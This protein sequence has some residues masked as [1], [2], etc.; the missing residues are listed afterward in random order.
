[1]E[2]CRISKTAT[3]P[4]MFWCLIV[5]LASNRIMPFFRLKVAGACYLFPYFEFADISMVGQHAS[6]VRGLCPPWMHDIDHIYCNATVYVGEGNINM[7][8]IICG[9]LSIDV[10]TSYS[11]L[12]LM[13]AH[14]MSVS[15]KP[16]LW[17]CSSRQW[18]CSH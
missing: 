11:N 15:F 7:I 18:Y 1:L 5:Q 12:Y 9:A 16:F 13:A 3:P 14:F 2:S 17:T 10:A 8:F 4:S 6:W